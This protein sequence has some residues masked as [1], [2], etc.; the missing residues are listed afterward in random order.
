MGDYMS[1]GSR[2]KEMREARQ[3]TRNQLAD[4][5]GV[6]VGAISNYENEVSFP[7]EPVLFKLIEILGCD[8]N[9]LF[10]DAIEMQS[11][12]N[13]VSVTEYELIQRYR[14]LDEYG[15]ETVI[16]ILDREADR[17]KQIQRMEEYKKRLDEMYGL[18]RKKGKLIHIDIQANKDS[19]CIID[20]AK[21]KK[22]GTV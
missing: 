15:R 2:I 21:T 6:T 16:Y 12:E 1:V 5:I 18:Y 8:A 3:F 14:E 10:Q 17:K 4:M 11:M 19:R 7:K 22:E 20:K 9:Y 13:K